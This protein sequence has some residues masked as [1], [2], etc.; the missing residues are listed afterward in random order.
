MIL[1][2]L[3]KSQTYEPKF[4]QDGS[5]RILDALS[6]SGLRAF[7]FSQEVGFFLVSKIEIRN[8]RCPM[9][10]M[11][12]LMIFRVF[13]SLTFLFNVKVAENA[14]ETIKKNIELNGVQDKVKAHFGDAV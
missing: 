5:I 7:R 13:F 11:C 10:L 12:W 9:C 1:V 4:L 2:Y 14:V 8:F 6:A 3:L